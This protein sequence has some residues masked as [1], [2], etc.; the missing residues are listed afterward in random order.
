MR[1]RVR[2]RA[3]APTTPV[4]SEPRSPGYALTRHR[5]VR[6]IVGVRFRVICGCAARLVLRYN[7][8]PCT[9]YASL[10]VLC[11]QSAELRVCVS[12]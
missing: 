4:R 5:S 12:A 11:R 10:D 8:P 6:P 9:A 1:K 3:A 2:G 7:A